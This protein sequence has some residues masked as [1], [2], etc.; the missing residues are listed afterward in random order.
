MDVP[1]CFEG[2]MFSGML[3]DA[4]QI[5]AKRRWHWWD[6]QEVRCEAAGPK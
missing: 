2:D 3:D 1:I 6:H 5:V 4:R